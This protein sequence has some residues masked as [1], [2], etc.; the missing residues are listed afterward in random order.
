MVKNLPAMQE[1]QVQ[2][3]VWEDSLEKG[4]F[5][6]SSILNWRIPWIEEARGLQS[7][8][9]QR[10]GHNWATLARDIISNVHLKI[11][12]NFKQHRNYTFHDSHISVYILNCWLW[13]INILEI[14]KHE[15]SPLLEFENSKYIWKV[16][17]WA[18][19]QKFELTSNIKFFKSLR[20]Q[21]SKQT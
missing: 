19:H 20:N 2:S 1:T 3:L 9:S 16:S 14:I 4:M 21:N 7:M 17:V 15:E 5:T 6:H 18:N 11:D 13:T 8:G 12:F 10:V